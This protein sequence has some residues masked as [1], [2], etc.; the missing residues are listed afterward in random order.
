VKIV[1][2]NDN[3]VE[4]NDNSKIKITLFDEPG[5]ISEG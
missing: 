4:T 2:E 5:I 1:N 3:K